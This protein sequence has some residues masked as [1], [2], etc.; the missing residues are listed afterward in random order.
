MWSGKGA[1]RAEIELKVGERVASMVSPRRAAPPCGGGAAQRV[2]S[3]RH[4][5][6]RVCADRKP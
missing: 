5:S 6:S 4:N 2:S 1:S 3:G